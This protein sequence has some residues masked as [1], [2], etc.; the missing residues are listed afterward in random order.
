MLTSTG[1]SPPPEVF[2]TAL[3]FVEDWVEKMGAIDKAMKLLTE[4][5]PWV[6]VG[7]EIIDLARKTIALQIARDAIVRTLLEDIRSL[8]DAIRE[9]YE[10]GGETYCRSKKRTMMKVVI[11]ARRYCVFVAQYGKKDSV[12]AR[13]ISNAMT[14]DS[15]DN[16][17]K[18][19]QDTARK[20][21]EEVVRDSTFAAERMSAQAID[22]LN[23]A[24]NQAVLQSIPYA[25]GASL[26]AD[27]GC[28]LPNTRTG[29][30][31][32]I[33]NWIL[34]PDE[35]RR[36]FFL[37]GVA[38]EGKSAIAHSVARQFKN[39]DILGSS[40]R[41]DRSDRDRKAALLFPTIA[42]DLAEFKHD[43]CAP[44]LQAVKGHTRL[45]MSTSL[46]EQFEHF[47]Q[48]PLEDLPL[49]APLVFVI[50]ALDECPDEDAKEL[51]VLLAQ[52]SERL[53]GLCR[54][55]ITSRPDASFYQLFSDSKN[56]HMEAVKSPTNEEIEVYIHH[57]LMGHV[58]AGDLHPQELAHLAQASQR[59]FQYAA[60]ACRTINEPPPGVGVRERYDQIVDLQKRAGP[61]AQGSDLMDQLY[62]DIL[63]RLGDEPA[64]LQ[65]FK[66]ALGLILVAETPLTVTILDALYQM[67][68]DHNC[69]LQDLSKH[70]GSVLHGVTDEA[71][72]VRILHSSFRD[73]L[74]DSKRAG[75]FFI[76][77]RK[78]QVNML[79]ASLKI[80]KA[81]LQL[82][83]ARV[84][85]S[86]TLIT[87]ETRRAAKVSTVQ[88]QSHPPTV[89]PAAS[90]MTDMEDTTNMEQ[91]ILGLSTG[92][93]ITVSQDCSFIAIKQR[94]R[95]YVYNMNTGHCTAVLCLEIGKAPTVWD[96]AFTSDGERLLLLAHSKDGSGT[97]EHPITWVWELKTGHRI[98]SCH[99]DGQSIKHAADGQST[100][101]LSAD[102]RW[103]LE[104][105]IHE[106]TCLYMWR[107]RDD[108]RSTPA[109]KGESYDGGPRH[110]YTM[111]VQKVVVADIHA[112]VHGRPSVIAT[113]VAHRG[114][115]FLVACG[116]AKGD[117]LLWEI[118]DARSPPIDFASTSPASIMPSAQSILKQPA[119]FELYDHGQIDKVV[120][121]RFS[122]DA[123]IATFG[124]S[125]DRGNCSGVAIWNI[126]QETPNTSLAILSTLTFKDTIMHLAL[127]S[128]RLLCVTPRDLKI[129]NFT[130][131]QR[132]FEPTSSVSREEVADGNIR[133]ISCD[134][135][136]RNIFV[137]D[138][139]P[140]LIVSVIDDQLDLHHG[141]AKC[142]RISEHQLYEKAI[143]EPLPLVRFSSPSADQNSA[144]FKQPLHVKTVAPENLHVLNS[145]MLPLFTRT[146][147]TAL[148]SDVWN[149][150]FTNSVQQAWADHAQKCMSWKNLANTSTGPLWNAYWDLDGM[151]KLS[152]S[153]N[154]GGWSG[155]FDGMDKVKMVAVSLDGRRFA[156][157]LD[158]TASSTSSEETKNQSYEIHVW[159]GISG[160][161]LYELNGEWLKDRVYQDTFRLAFSPDGTRLAASNRIVAR[162]IN[163]DPRYRYDMRLESKV[164]VPMEIL[165][166][167]IEP[168]N[169]RCAVG[170]IDGI[171]IWDITD[172]DA[173]KHPIGDLMRCIGSV[174]PNGVCSLAYSHD[175]QFLVS[176]SFD[177]VVRVWDVSLNSEETF[178]SQNPSI[179]F[180]DTPEHALQFPRR[181][182]DIPDNSEPEQ[183]PD[184]YSETATVVAG[185]ETPVPFDRDDGDNLR[186]R[187]Q[188][189]DAKISDG[190]PR[191]SGCDPKMIAATALESMPER[192]IYEDIDPADPSTEAGPAQEL[193]IEDIYMKPDGWI[194]AIVGTEERL[195]LWVPSEEHR[196]L[197][198]Q[199]REQ[200]RS[201]PGR[202]NI[203]LS[204]FV[205]GH[206]WESC[207]DESK[208]SLSPNESIKRKSFVGQL[209]DKCSYL[210]RLESF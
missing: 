206:G 89:V 43:F 73:F 160:E 145:R 112:P 141:S 34:D 26:L 124:Y 149:D 38:G 25:R 97:V 17:I 171:R 147:A 146:G 139:T 59:Y 69:R 200:W 181:L 47:I 158:T 99:L 3:D 182:L 10:Q 209:Y 157:I 151:S 154:Y 148:S 74:I 180:S 79:D 184:Q 190:E 208:S 83:I 142:Q 63:L 95:V 189:L 155:T 24:E 178:T 5:H 28:C 30:L 96:M 21:K 152:K 197:V 54:I 128:N 51:A 31:S 170:F 193:L 90:D 140:K 132:D 32:E 41:F 88:D 78:A 156:A 8:Y 37:Y 71:E 33:V 106:P 166:M 50:D 84:S 161:H 186:D 81:K 18:E 188:Q 198:F 143:D 42:R 183:E 39:L 105:I 4:V 76:D 196:K 203:D 102:G 53:P 87:N 23:D 93:T 57:Q 163:L 111:R 138:D 114:Q 136:G 169:R 12:I 109:C 60:V 176:M 19:Y 77:E 187:L 68:V 13:A 204:K 115:K 131:T 150:E 167:A 29:I 94:A 27:K 15:V 126:A 6:K 44:F 207:Y 191:H 67:L 125:Y 98:F 101:K 11:H 133:F 199:M 175:G 104:N 48:K 52:A 66:S 80:M 113:S 173:R 7:W 130:R 72:S 168:S 121:I 164:E 20:L 210:T 58:D 135:D 202:V 153:A 120:A 122:A 107:I 9:A 103:L 192:T 45:Q 117:V 179:I 162:V 123:R 165:C 174:S 86:Y 118:D 195:L 129:V 116:F 46:S 127:A 14:L 49:D 194:V 119:P 56:V 16:I 85:S 144:T 185:Q 177:M 55:L 159:D 62:R 2:K 108:E 36:V 91:S 61:E 70:L 64:T 100:Y 22:M 110:S 205:H 65:R 92:N 35:S 75:E 134:S 40:F 1:N 82:N 137:V 201:T 172:R